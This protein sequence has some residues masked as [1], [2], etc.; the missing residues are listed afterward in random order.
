ME[1]EGPPLVATTHPR[2]WVRAGGGG[3]RG[4]QRRSDLANPW[5]QEREQGLGGFDSLAW[6]G[7]L[8]GKGELGHPTSPLLLP[9]SQT[10]L[11]RPLSTPWVHNCRD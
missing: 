5:N 3:R 2:S 1:A 8:G 4:T 11:P 10:P 6:T 9:S 7:L